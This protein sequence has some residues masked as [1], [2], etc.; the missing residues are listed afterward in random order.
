M[1]FLQISPVPS[2]YST[3]M[4]LANRNNRPDL[5]FALYED[6]KCG[7]FSSVGV[8]SRKS[9]RAAK[10]TPDEPIFLNL[11]RAAAGQGDLSRAD[12]LLAVMKDAAVKV[13]LSGWCGLV[14]ICLTC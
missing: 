14:R 5:V 11:L 12:A 9:F 3:L 8:S 10:M 6:M 4:L 1:K 7:F 2:T 13:G